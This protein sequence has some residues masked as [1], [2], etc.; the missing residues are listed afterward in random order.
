MTHSSKQAHFHNVFSKPPVQCAPDKCILLRSLIC[1]FANFPCF[2]MM[3][4]APSHYTRPYSTL[5]ISLKLPASVG[6]T[7]SKS[8]PTDVS[9]ILNIYIGPVANVEMTIFNKF[10]FAP[11]PCYTTLLLYLSLTD[12]SASSC[13]CPPSGCTRNQQIIIKTIEAVM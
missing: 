6:L 5:H 3:L 7:L 4:N 9:Q 12:V 10:N 1:A 2:L 8:T 13:T 11:I